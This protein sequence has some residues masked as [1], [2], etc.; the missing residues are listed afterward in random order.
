MPWCWGMLPRGCVGAPGALTGPGELQ[1]PGSVWEH[2][3]AVCSSGYQGSEGWGL[4]ISTA[5][6]S[7]V[8]EAEKSRLLDTSY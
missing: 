5:F 3:H 2:V 7:K 4:L 1:E 6:S 8:Q